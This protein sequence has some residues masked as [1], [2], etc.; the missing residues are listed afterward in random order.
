MKHCL[1]CN[2]ELIEDDDEND[3][4]IIS[5][6]SCEINFKCS[7]EACDKRYIVEFHPCD[8]REA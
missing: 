6:D 1:S 2:S 5:I 7:D 3:S 8:L 4:S